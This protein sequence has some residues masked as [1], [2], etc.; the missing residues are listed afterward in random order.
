MDLRVIQDNK[1]IKLATYRYKQIG[2][3]QPKAIVLLFHGL[4]SSVSHGSHV[5]KALAEAGL[6]VVGFDHRGFGASEGIRGFIESKE[7]HL[8]DCRLFVNNIEKIYGKEIKKFC[9][10]LSMGGMVSYNLTLES[11]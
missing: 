7:I 11:P 4:N 9:A 3:E 10:G 1:T 8:S 5:A 6:C 2:L